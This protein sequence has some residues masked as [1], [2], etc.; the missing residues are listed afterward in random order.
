MGLGS[1]GVNVWSV[2]VVLN[3][4][5]LLSLFVCLGSKVTCAEYCDQLIMI[6]ADDYGYIWLNEQ[7][8]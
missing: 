6:V 1:S 7:Y 3:V 5:A 4:V 2:V 8:Y